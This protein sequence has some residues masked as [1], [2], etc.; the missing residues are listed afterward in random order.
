MMGAE[1]TLH[2]VLGVHHRLDSSLVLLR[3]LHGTKRGLAYPLRP[4]RTGVG[5]RAGTGSWCKRS[6]LASDLLRDSLCARMMPFAD[7][8]DFFAAARRNLP[9]R[10]AFRTSIMCEFGCPLK[11]AAP[12]LSIEPEICS[13]SLQSAIE[14]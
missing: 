6:G 13:L 7:K 12:A 1:P 2:W 9:M 11:V 3:W 14:F 4:V 10:Q 5:L 8:R